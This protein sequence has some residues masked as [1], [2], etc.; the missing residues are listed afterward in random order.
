MKNAYGV[1]LD[2]HGYAPSILQDYERCFICYK[3]GDLQRHEV[4]NASNKTRSKELGLWVNLCPSCHDDVHTRKPELRKTL[5]QIAQAKAM[6]Y[7]DW[8]FEEFR[9][10][11]GKSYLYE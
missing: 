7:Y 1:T 10:E 9:A 11:F 4:F 6:D 8:T 5:K 3:E 2:R